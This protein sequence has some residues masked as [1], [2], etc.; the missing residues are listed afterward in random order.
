MSGMD[1]GE[2]GGA[3][4]VSSEG[5]FTAVNQRIV[6]SYWYAIASVVATMALVRLANHFQRRRRLEL[7]KTSP[8]AIPPSPGGKFVQA[9]AAATAI[10]RELAY[11]QPF[12]FR[13]R[14][15]KYLSPLPAGKWLLLAIYWTALLILLWSNS[16]LT[17]GDSMYA[18]KWEKVGFRAAWVSVT[19]IPFIFLLSCKFNP[20][21]ILI[22]ISYERLNWLHRW[23][24]RTIFLTVIVHWSYFFREW[25]LA[26]FVE[27]EIQMMPMVKYGFGAFATIGWMILSGFGFFRAMGY[28]FFVIQHIAAFAVL[29]WLLHAHVP[30]YARYNIYMSVGFVASDWSIRT[31]GGMVRNFHLY[32]R[33]ALRRVGYKVRVQILPGHAVRLT[34]DDAYFRW[35][36]GQ[37]I[38]L[39]I[40]FLRLFELHPFT[41][42]NACGKPDHN[43]RQLTMLIKARSGFTKTLH[44]VASKNYLSS[45]RFLAFLSGPWG[46]PP[47]PSS[48][49]TVVLIACS[50][51][52]SF[53]TPILEQLVK[54]PGCV[55]RIISHWIIRS[56]KHFI[57]FEAALRALELDAK[58]QGLDLEIF[59]HVTQ[60]SDV[61]QTQM[62]SLEPIQDLAK[63]VTVDQS[64][65]KPGSLSREDERIARSVTSV[66]DEKRPLSLG[67]NG[68]SWP[69]QSLQLVHRSRPSVESMIRPPVEKALGETSIIVCGGLSITAQ[70]RTFVAAIS[71]ER[72]VHKGTGAQSISLHTEMYGW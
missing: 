31:I 22:G 49:D 26:D 20:L 44:N 72:A 13:G 70:A 45:Q 60:P 58:A 62:Q 55:R 66:D 52:A 35:K 25:W 12:F 43:Y 15:S 33:F 3:M 10:C 14:M 32:E 8:Y 36:A 71:D 51:G 59:I 27:L 57:W 4:D 16:I 30:S 48:C 19:Q 69:R 50:S 63:S 42:A 61:S 40:P 21:S 23:A 29:L 68:Y 11:P 24:A 56:E 5:L 47:N 6:L 34:I 54:C 1:M 65:S 2:M 37:H 67:G 17:P 39:S 38:Y 9:Y 28:E 18:Y 7:H 64:A 41:V 46:I 53:T